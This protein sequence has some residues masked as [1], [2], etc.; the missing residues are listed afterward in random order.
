MRIIAGKFKGRKIYNPTDNITRP[1]KDRVRESIFNIIEHSKEMNFDLINSNVLDLYS[2]VGSFGLECLSRGAKQVYF[3]E[4]YIPALKILKKNIKTLG[5][6][7]GC[8][9][10]ESDVE[11]IEDT[12]KFTNIKFNLVFLDPPFAKKN[13]N[14]IIDKIYHMKILKDDA[15]IIIHCNKNSSEK[16]SEKLE[17]LRVESYGKSKII[18]SQISDFFN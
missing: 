10:I 12:F 1:L 6:E 18:F 17:E 2:G 7:D 3:F 13:I 15:L 9:I 4:K 16:Y 14:L 11:K 5:Y 8:E